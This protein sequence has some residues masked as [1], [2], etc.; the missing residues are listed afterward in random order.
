MTTPRKAVVARDRASPR[1]AT[2]GSDFRE[3]LRAVV[4]RLD[5]VSFPSTRW[6]NDPVLFAWEVLG[7]RLRD[8]QVMML[9]AM[10]HH[11]RTTIRSGQ[12]CGKTL[13][14]CI[15]ALWFYCSFADARVICTANTKEQ[16]DR[17]IWRQIRKLVRGAVIPIDG[18]LGDHART[19]LHSAD[20][21]E[22]TGYT[23]AEV[24][25]VS[26][27]SG[28]N[29]LYLIDEASALGAVLAEAIEGNCA[30]GRARVVYIS[31]P[32]RNEGPF[33]DSHMR[34]GGEET[35]HRIHINCEDVAGVR[36][37][38][39]ENGRK[40]CV[41][42]RPPE[43][44]GLAGELADAAQIRKWGMDEYPVGSAFYTVRVRGE[45]VRNET[46]KAIT[47][48]TITCSQKRHE[49]ASD[50]G[51]LRI[52][53]DPAGPGK[54]GDEW[55]FVAVK[56]VKVV[57]VDA[58]SGLSD[59]QAIE[60]LREIIR[61]H[62]NVGERPRVNVDAEGP[63]GWSFFTRLKGIA[64]VAQ[65]EHGFDCYAVRGSGKATRKPQ[66]YPRVRDELY[67]RLNE[68][69]KDEGAI[70]L[71]HKLEQDLHA[72]TWIGQLD[73]RNKLLD[74]IEV[75]KV[76]GRSPDR[77][78]ALALAVWTPMAYAD[79]GPASPEPRPDYEWHEPASPYDSDITD[80]RNSLP[81]D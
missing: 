39:R 78:D 4:L 70:P 77:G 74:K 64:N 50:T 45:F 9:E 16:I 80:P 24:E 3:A 42:V 51:P 53:L 8:Y 7:I 21:R 67:A 10:M 33:Y 15:A 66:L 22:I 40:E 17:V 26:G 76:L 43:N 2:L 63:I 54:A 59:D 19:G 73:G 28:R 12:K 27:V 58:V 11:Q 56:G 20:F 71:D 79:D 1:T 34:P 32:T 75:R 44:D 35:W 18:E 46:G 52:G 37:F 69:L 6:Q 41:Q 72:P 13:C 14:I 31:N 65:G 60:K 36:W 57:V 47:L 25:A 48:D 61:A 68:W 38:N 29:L 23:S 49:A 62:R 81:L 5:T 55:A 30:G